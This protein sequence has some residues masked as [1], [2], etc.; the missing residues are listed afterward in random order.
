MVRAAQKSYVPQEIERRILKLWSELSIFE[1][2]ME[3]K[4]ERK[5]FVFLEGPPTANGEPHPGHLFTRA[6]KDTV[7]RYQQMRG[8]WVFRK[9]GWDTH[10]LPVEIEVEKELG[11][12]NKRDIENYGINEFNARCRESVF[13][14]INDWN[15]LTK[16]SGFWIDLNNPYVTYRNEYI[17]SVWWSLREAW[18]KGLLYKGHKVVPYCPRCSTALSSHEVA[19]G[20]REVEDPSIYVKFEVKGDKNLYL[21][22]WTTTPWT[23]I[24]NAA[25]AVN[26][27]ENYVK[28]KLKGKE[29][30]LILEE[31]SAERIFKPEEYEKI[32][33]LSGEE[34][35]GIEYEPLFSF[36]KPEKRCWYVIPADWVSTEEGTGV[37][38]VAP[39]F[40]EDDYEAGKMHGLPVIQLVN[41]E[42]KFKPEVKPWAGKFVKD[43][44]PGII[45][46]LRERGML[47]KYEKYK[48]EYPFCW[49]CETPL[50]YFAGESWFIKMSSLKD[51]LIKIN[52]EVNWFPGHIKNGRFGEFIQ[53]PKD[54][55][56]SR[57]RFWGTPLPIWVCE[58]CGHI[59]C[60]GSIEELQEK[61]I[62]F[63]SGLDL[64][65]PWVDKIKLKCE[66]CGGE[67]S[68]TT[69]VIDA[70]YDSGC[71]PFAQFHYPFE[72]REM[73]ERLF[74]ADFVTE[75]IDQT[76]GWFYS[77]LSISTFL[78]DLTPYK[79]VLVLEL[80]LNKDG[81]KMSKSKHNYLNPIK[82]LKENGADPVRWYLLTTNAPW[83]PKR[84]YEEAITEASNRFLSTLWNVWYFFTSYAELDS[85]NPQELD[86]GVKKNSSI[87]RWL[88]SRLNAL[89]KEVKNNM[90]VFEIHKATRAIEDFVIN[91]LSN[92]WIRRCRKR[93]WTEEMT[94][95]KKSAYSTLWETLL[96][97]TKLLAPFIPFIAEEMYQN[98]RNNSMPESVHMEDYPEC[99]EDCIDKE[100]E[101]EMKVLRE[102]TEAGRA[103]RVKA[104]IKSRYPLPRAV[105]IC[106]KSK[107]ETLK[108]LLDLL[109]QELNLKQ[110]EIGGNIQEFTEIKLRTNRASIGKKFRKDAKK[111]LDALLSMDPSTIA[112]ELETNGVV[113][114]EVGNNMYEL[115]KEDVNIQHEPKG[116]FLYSKLD[117]SEYLVLDC[118]MTKELLGEGFANEL[119]RRIQEMRKRADLQMEEKIRVEFNL[120]QDKQKLIE[121]YLS[122]I[123]EETRAEK[124]QMVDEP[125]GDL[126]MN[127]KIEREE[128]KIG[129]K[130]IGGKYAL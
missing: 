51:R 66:K 20:Y 18:K 17:E 118:S 53:N 44:D 47:L 117:D 25:L 103:L 2:Q 39:G 35:E 82:V 98:L 57:D 113:T 1:K 91:D 95:D 62:E 130:R 40:G 61:S 124:L 32:E 89:I 79:N 87:D 105:L 37:V 110:V 97:L 115:N 90:E 121:K 108:P 126:V 69:Q 107:G 64:H 71:A 5:P 73:F 93:F 33:R 22:A 85:F 128:I 68:R 36:I 63:P 27:Q 11:L 74:P 26:P 106:E 83:A 23:L 92:W 4:E 109:R 72:N 104:G 120:G 28:I 119:I 102:L 60:I 86:T 59:S 84:F 15:E 12:K 45:E 50:I 16:L 58:K 21:L 81:E 52:S 94:K 43:A 42:G 29:E 41:N 8:Y 48:H 88:I 125:E 129:I 127:W 100:L 77:L 38:H 46:N 123:S 49:R 114:L 31:K 70:W 9:A 96:E 122:F 30:V 75:A 3:N 67:M 10:G 56:L 101:Q 34:L 111:V 78:F 65:K 7:L 19:Q 24:S 14:Y 99:R 6:V 80:I 55:A 116:N 54:W 112:G 76:R 13:K